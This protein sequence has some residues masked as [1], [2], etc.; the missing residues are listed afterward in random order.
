MKERASNNDRMYESMDEPSSND[1]SLVGF[2]F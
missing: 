2:R 1:R